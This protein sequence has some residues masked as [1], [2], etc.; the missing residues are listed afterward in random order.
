VFQAIVQ[1]DKIGIQSVSQFFFFFERKKGKRKKNFFLHWVTY[2]LLW[3]CLILN[4]QIH[5]IL[6]NEW[7]IKKLFARWVSRILIAMQKQ[8]CMQTSVNLWRCL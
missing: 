4:K 1:M 7:N 2:S 5:F 6:H 8:V 3:N